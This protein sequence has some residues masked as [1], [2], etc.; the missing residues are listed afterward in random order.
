[1]KKLWPIFLWLFLA[2]PAVAQNVQ[3]P[4]RPTADS[5]NACANTRFVH[6]AGGGGGG[7]GFNNIGPSVLATAAVLPNTPTYSNGTLG[8]GATLTAGS[9]TTLT[10]DATAAP[11]ATVVLVKNQAAPEQNG[12]YTVTIAGSGAAPW[13]LT[14][15]TYFDQAAE[16][17]AGSY[18]YITGGTANLNSAWQLQTTVVT[19]GTSPLNWVLFAQPA[20][21]WTQ[22]GGDVYRPSGN[23]GIGAPPSGWTGGFEGLQIISGSI[24]HT[25]NDTI[26]LY[27]NIYWDGLNYRLINNGF[28]GIFAANDSGGAFNVYMF[29]SGTSGSIAIPTRR[30]GITNTG[31]MSLPAYGAGVAVLDSSGVVASK[32]SYTTS[33]LYAADY[34]CLPANSAATNNANCQAAITACLVTGCILQLP[35]GTI[36]VSTTLTCNGAITIQGVVAGGTGIGVGTNKGTVISSSAAGNVFSCSSFDAIQFRDFAISATGTTTGILIISP[37]FGIPSCLRASRIERMFIT[38]GGKGISM[39]DACNF[40]IDNN[41]IFNTTTTGI[42][43]SSAGA[44]LQDVGDYSVKGNTVWDN[45]GTASGPG[46]DLVNS[47][48]SV[49]ANKVLGFTTGIAL[50]TVASV[51]GTMLINSNQIEEFKISCVSVSQNGAGARYGFVSINLNQCQAGNTT[52]QRGIVINAGAVPY[53]TQVVIGGN[54]INLGGTAF[55]P[56]SCIDINDGD[57][58]NVHD[59][60]CNMNSSGSSVG[61]ST[62]NN[63]TNVQF[64]NNQVKNVSSRYSC[65]VAARALDSVS[66]PSW[67]NC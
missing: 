28:G 15:V 57:L 3:C 47:G 45:T 51:A 6:A 8:V 1:M 65:G 54:I 66:F 22:S 39:R 5:S 24:I 32:P 50:S 63:A 12:V 35:A 31:T 42:E 13:V 58:V 40:S 61:F 55:V 49:I 23:V 7:G 46:M 36:N 10:V 59:N 17:L 33:I 11:L 44:F 38:G 62:A 43:I 30:F 18:T 53:L 25:L 20:G 67:S 21:L 2:F 48:G 26:G 19:V 14:R 56:A 60:N 41:F 37:N 16:M 29:P 27:G 64:A 52:Y 4:D 34:G 9:N